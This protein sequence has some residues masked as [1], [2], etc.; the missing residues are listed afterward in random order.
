[1]RHGDLYQFLRQHHPENQYTLRKKHQKI[2]RYVDTLVE[3]EMPF[4]QKHKC[5]Q[6]NYYVQISNELNYINVLTVV[7]MGVCV[8][9]PLRSLLV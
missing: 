6:H 8:T 3:K 7:V 1:M 5:S 2:L 4:Q 9:W